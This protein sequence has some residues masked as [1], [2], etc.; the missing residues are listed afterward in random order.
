MKKQFL[1]IC[2]LFIVMPLF[3]ACEMG[4]SQPHEHSYTFNTILPTINSDG[5]TSYI[6][7]CGYEYKDNYTVLLKFVSVNEDG[8]VIDD[9]IIE[10]KIVS[11]NSSFGGIT[12]DGFYRPIEYKIGNNRLNLGDKITRSATITIIFE[13]NMSPEIQE[14]LDTVK[15]LQKLVDISVKYNQEKS[16]TKNPEIRAMQYIRTANYNGSNWNMVAGTLESDF[17]NYV[18]QNKEDIDVL[19][20][21]SINEMNS[22]IESKSVDFVHL[23][24][25]MNAICYSNYSNNS[26]DLAGWGGDL[27]QLVGN[28]K[29]VLN[30]SNINN[31]TPKQIANE[32]FNSSIGGF[33]SSDVYADLDAVNMA[34]LIKNT[35]KSLPNVFKDYYLNGTSA[36][37]SS[38]INNVFGNVVQDVATLSGTIYSRVTNNY[39]IQI[40]CNQNGISTTNDAQIFVACSEVFAEYLLQE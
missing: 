10:D 7:E 5:Y 12:H 9:I 38:F 27:A 25:S 31:K 32:Y 4:G 17:I 11:K 37:K 26:S 40:W 1:F 13:N 29:S 35:N 8:Q 22:P 23:F 30:G 21:R 20:L 33:S 16:L 28:V 6:C 15:K 18:E 39:L 3:T 36:S 14:F 24:A 19:S 34:Y 2:L